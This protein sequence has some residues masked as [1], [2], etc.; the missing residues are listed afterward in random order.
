MK[1]MS[2]FHSRP[3]TRWVCLPRL[4]QSRPECER[5]RHRLRYQLPTQDGPSKTVEKGVG[6]SGTNDPRSGTACLLWGGKPNVRCRSK[7]GRS[8]R[9]LLSTETELIILFQLRLDAKLKELLRETRSS[10]LDNS[11]LPYHPLMLIVML[12][13]DTP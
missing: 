7:D 3:D 8:R 6:Y 2:N 12:L 11:A 5:N 4:T 1:D 10:S 9:R 13:G